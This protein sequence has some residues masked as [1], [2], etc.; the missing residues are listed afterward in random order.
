MNRSTVDLVI[1]LGYDH[2][3]TVTSYVINEPLVCVTHCVSKIL[4]QVSQEGLKSA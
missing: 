3:V 2:H 4:L 1:R